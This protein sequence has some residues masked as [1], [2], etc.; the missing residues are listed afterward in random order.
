MKTALL[1]EL[2]YNRGTIVFC[3][4][5]AFA[6]S[7]IAATALETGNLIESLYMALIII[8]LVLFSMNTWFLREGRERMFIKMPIGINQIYWIRL[9]VALL[10]IVIPLL[11]FLLASGSVWALLPNFDLMRVWQNLV[12]VCVFTIIL[13]LLVFILMDLQQLIMDVFPFAVAVVVEIIFAIAVGV[14]T[15]TLA[16]SYSRNETADRT[17]LNI[18]NFEPEEHYPIL[19]V[20]SLIAVVL[21]RVIFSVRRSFSDP[22]KGFL[23]I[24]LS[25]RNKSS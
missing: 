15:A 22:K 12:S 25:E 11:L 1:N 13:M 9:A 19:I 3:L 10:I 17:F 18:P 6:S 8:K 2:Q 24:W 23:L 21:G 16:I 5:I 4:V 14:G 7:L 20:I